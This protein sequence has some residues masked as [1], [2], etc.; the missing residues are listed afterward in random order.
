[1]RVL[2]TRHGDVALPAF[3]PDATRGVIRALDSADVAAAGVEALVVNAYHLM[4]KPG[5]RVVQSLGG[6]HAFMRWDRPV[7]VDSGGFQVFSLIRQRPNMGAIRKDEVIFRSPYD[8]EK[9][10]LTPQKCIEVQDH[11]GAD[12]MMCLDDCTHAD[13]G[14]AE[15]TAAVDRTIR[16]ARLC[17]TAFDHLNNVQNKWGQ[18]LFSRPLI[19]GIVQGGRDLT[20]RKRCAEALIEI[21][22]DGYALGGWPLDH[23]GALLTD[24]LAAVAQ[25]LPPDKPRYAMGI[26]KPENVVACVR[27]G[28]NLF[29]CVIPT[30]DARHHHAFAFNAASVGAIDLNRPDFYARLN[31]AG[32]QHVR[33]DAPISPLCDCPTCRTYSRAYLRHLFDIKDSLA[34]RLV[35]IHNLRFYSLLMERLRTTGAGRQASGGVTTNQGREAG[36]RPCLPAGRKMGG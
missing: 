35:S 21:G 23:H 33:D 30:R 22:F 13:E 15:Q 17:R 25:L 34:G 24:T 12:I 18:T 4:L 14:S 11:L 28:Y 9:T 26:G 8:G 32:G 36:G 29:D 20:L 5:A 31:F 19:F 7:L 1:M 2:H 6:V 27:M 10:I 3:L 16:W